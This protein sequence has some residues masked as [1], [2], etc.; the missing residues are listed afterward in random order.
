MGPELSITAWHSGH[1]SVRA[2]DSLWGW[3]LN[4]FVL[5]GTSSSELCLEERW[6]EKVN[7]FKIHE[8]FS[9][10]MLE[11]AVNSC[12]VWAT[13]DSGHSHFICRVSLYCCGSYWRE[14][15]FPLACKASQSFQWWLPYQ[16]FCL[17]RYFHVHELK[18]LG[19]VLK[20]NGSSYRLKSRHPQSW[21]SSY[22]PLIL[23]KY[24]KDWFIKL[25]L[26]NASRFA[27][28]REF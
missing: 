7:H 25:I 9:N 16:G 13:G 27:V 23:E 4:P 26:H 17:P 20:I 6:T 19:A 28:F 12:F 1:P 8:R 14:L 10:R 18:H 3:G 5:K 21:I 2:S 22:D 24:G 11:K 15:Q